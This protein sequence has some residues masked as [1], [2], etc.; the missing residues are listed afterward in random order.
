MKSII[1]L[2]TIL[3]VGGIQPTKAAPPDVFTSAVLSTAEI[4]TNYSEMYQN[5]GVRP[6]S[7]ADLGIDESYFQSN[8]VSHLDIEPV[9]GS[10]MIGL[11]PSF[12]RNE[13]IAFVPIFTRLGSIKWACQTTVPQS[14]VANTGCRANVSYEALTQILDRNLFIDTLI[15]TAVLRL[16]A[17]ELYTTTAQFPES[18]ADYEID[19]QWLESAYV[20]HFIVDPNSKTILL[21]LDEIYGINQ[22][23]VMTPI[24]SSNA[25]LGW[26]YKTTL[27]ASLV[28]ISGVESDVKLEDLIEQ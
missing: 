3:T 16:N 15:N 22:W 18:M 23:L 12:G 24:F 11:S 28:N 19:Q 9:S 25:I 21:G 26:N 17:N 8:L 14:L 10:L 7:L 1:A 5:Q 20:D 4:R 2:L 13:W 27:P 6:T